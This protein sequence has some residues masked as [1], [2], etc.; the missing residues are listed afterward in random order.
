MAINVSDTIPTVQT[1]EQFEE[2]LEKYK[3]TN[4]T[5]YALKAANG[6]FDRQRKL[7]GGET[8][9]TAPTLEEIPK[10]GRPRKE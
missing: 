4:P 8:K 2:V 7:L 6:D 1:L 5:K 9:V 3:V 10:L